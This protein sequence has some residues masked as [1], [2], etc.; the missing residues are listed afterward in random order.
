LTNSEFVFFQTAIE[1][2][3]QTGGGFFS[4][5]FS[6]L[7]GGGGGGGGL[8]GLFGMILPALFG[9]GGGV[10]GGGGPAIPSVM[11]PA[12]AFRQAPK[13]AMG[14]PNV[15]GGV[16]A[17]LHNNE[18]VVPLTGGRKIPIEGGGASGG[19]G[20]VINQT[21]NITTPDADSFRK[22]QSQI[23]A[24]AASSGQRALSKNR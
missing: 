3:S 6:G 2:G 24:D 9:S 21:F 14:S 17:I 16:P 11:A 1:Q 15:T 20:Q 22:S 7:F 23:A 12:T 18:A 19:G 5:I 10:T 4:Q 13:Y 8:G